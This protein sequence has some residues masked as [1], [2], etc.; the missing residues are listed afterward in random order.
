MKTSRSTVLAC[1]CRGTIPLDRAGLASACGALEPAAHELC[2][3]DIG[4][5]RTAVGVGPV[6]VGC[7]QEAPAFRAEHEASGGTSA[8]SFV[9]IRETAGWSDEGARSLPKIAALVAEAQMLA[10]QGEAVTLSLRSEG[11]TLIYGRDERA[12]EAADRLKD[13]LDLTVMLTGPARADGTLEA[14]AMP[15]P[16]R[17]VDYPVVRGT[18]RT[19][20]GHLGAFELDIDGYALGD[21]SSR[22]V[23]AFEPP[24]NGAKSRCDL[25]IDLTG[26]TP[27]FAGHAKR[28]G[29][30]RPDPGDALAVQA[31]L[32]AAADLVGTFDRPRYVSIDPALCAHARSGQIG[33]T[34]CLDNCPAGALSPLADTAI[35]DPYVCAGCGTCAAVCPTGAVRWAAPSIDTGAEAV[36]A[37]LRTMLLAYRAAGGTVPP[38]ILVHDRTH[39]EPLIDALARVGDGLPAR[40]IPFCEPRV[41]GLDSLAAAFAFGAAEVRLLV[42]RVHAAEREALAREVALLEALLLPLGYGEGRV[43]VIDVDDPFLLGEA[44]RALPA[45]AGPEAA[46]F[47]PTGGKRDITRQALEALHAAAPTRVDEIALP[48]GAPIGRVH[49][50]D[51]CTLCLACVSV[52]PTSALRD[53]KDRPLLSFVED[54]CVQCGLCQSTCPERVITLEPRAT[55][56]PARREAVVLR[57]EAPALC[58]SCGKAF[59]TQASIDRVAAQLVGQHWMFSDPAVID[60]IYMC[61]DCRMRSHARAGFDPYA[62]GPR[63][64]TRT[65]DDYRS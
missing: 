56:G 60:R 9:N 39:G 12:I 62:G 59:G 25:I 24:R 57:E 22:R 31:A 18:I 29:Y 61:A 44:L 40:V 16:A 21:P 13:R 4:R 53:G 20:R 19:A 46:S 42:G 38:V 37:R 26:G 50:A 3:A 41:L 36:A 23:L 33:C 2:R 5:F 15:T 14:D 49:V 54:N 28:D 51:G 1:T 45:R 32:F 10:G 47:L 35:V 48:A 65:A 63:P 58:R 11:V 64:R 30:L 34:R 7:T 8:L 43:G 6:L 52:C 17:V 55:F 27:L